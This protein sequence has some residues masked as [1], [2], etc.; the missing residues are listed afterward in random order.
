MRWIGDGIE[1][2]SLDRHFYP[3]HFPSLIVFYTGRQFSLFSTWCA[4]SSMPP[5]SHIYIFSCAIGLI[6]VNL[7]IIDSFTTLLSLLFS[8][9]FSLSSSCTCATASRRFSYPHPSR[10][11]SFLLFSCRRNAHH[12]HT[13]PSLCLSLYLSL[14]PP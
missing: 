8:A 4:R 10:C 5:S 11:P 6:V 7:S 12:T 3:A 1:N 2:K 14:T 13:Y 9:Y